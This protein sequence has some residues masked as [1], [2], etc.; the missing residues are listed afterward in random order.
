[1]TREE[2]FEHAYFMLL[3]WIDA[4]S[5]GYKISD[6]FEDEDISTIAIYGMGELAD[7]LVNGLKNSEIKILYG[8]DRDPACSVGNIN[9][10]YSTE[11]K[12]YPA[13]DAVIIMPFYDYDNIEEM[14]RSKVKTD[15]FISIEEII[16]SL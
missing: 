1:M 3:H 15:R 13:V 5:M 11:E 8:I 14:L 2:R 12:N 10:I 4:L 16:W 9:D 7:R 6:Y